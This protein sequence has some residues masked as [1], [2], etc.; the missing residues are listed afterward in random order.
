MVARGVTGAETRRRFFAVD[1]GFSPAKKPVVAA[2]LTAVPSAT[3]PLASTP[4]MATRRDARTRA[5]A[6]ESN[7][8]YQLHQQLTNTTASV[9]DNFDIYSGGDDTI[10]RSDLER[11]RDSNDPRVTRAMKNHARYLLDHPAAMNALD[12]GAHKGEV[13][14]KISRRDLDGA[15]LELEGTDWVS[16]ETIGVEG[17]IDSEEEALAT[18]ERY[19]FLTDTAGG[20]GGRNGHYSNDDVEALLGDDSL[21]PD[22]REAAQYIADNDVDLRGDGSSFF[23]T[24]TSPFRAG[25]DWFGD[26]AGDAAGTGRDIFLGPSRLSEEERAELDEAAASTDNSNADLPLNEQNNAHHTNT[27]EEMLDALNGDYQWLEGDI[28]RNPPIM[29]HD[30]QSNDGMSLEEWLAIGKESGRGMKLDIKEGESVDAVIAA[31]QQSGIPEDQLIFNADVMAGPGGSGRN[32]SPEDLFKIREAFPNATIAIGTVTG[33]TDEGTTYTEAQ[34]SDM[35]ALAEAVGGPVMFPLRAELVTPQIVERLEAHGTVA[36]WNSPSTYPLS[37]SE[38]AAAEQRF[39]DMGV[40][41]IIDLRA[42]S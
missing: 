19:R 37:E 24:I 13:D 26:R 35:I 22:L 5:L 14:G 28:R 25:A 6:G 1:D 16:G 11:V 2:P 21:P 42:D 40:T 34:V 23:G 30:Y 36:I 32:V 9:R 31:V 7:L 10:T 8:A 20:K 33:D 4:S 17:A 18:L 38:V 15:A 12:T 39:R 41:G 27:K 3:V 29:A